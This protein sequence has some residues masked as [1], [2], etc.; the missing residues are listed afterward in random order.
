MTNDSA[1][2]EVDADSYGRRGLGTQIQLDS[3]AKS[4][5]EK[6]A[7]VRLPRLTSDEGPPIFFDPDFQSTIVEI[8]GAD[9]GA[10]FSIARVC[11]G[12]VREQRAGCLLRRIGSTYANT[13]AWVAP[14]VII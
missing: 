2:V 13:C 3:V 11:C 12:N 1:G 8:G 14:G 10:F 4:R 6:W 5:D 7:L 9:V